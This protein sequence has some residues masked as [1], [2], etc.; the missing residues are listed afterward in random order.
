[1]KKGKNVK[2]IFSHG[3]IMHTSPALNEDGLPLG[4]LD[5]KIF[6]R[7]AYPDDRNNDKLPIEEKESY[8][9]LESLKNYKD[10]LKETKVITICDREAD[11]YELFNLSY[12]INAP[13]LVRAK[14]NRAINKR[15]RYSEEDHLKLWDFMIRQP[16]SGKFDVEVPAKDNHPARIATVELKFGSFTFN[17]PRNIIKYSTGDLPNLKM[18]AIFVCEKNPPS[19]IDPLEWMLLTNLDVN[20]FEEAFEKVRWYCFRW[21]IEMFHKVLKSGFKVED[22]RLGEADR[23]INYLTIMS[24]VAWRIFMVTLIARTN[25]DLPCNLYLNNEEWKV[26]YMK[27]N[28]KKTWPKKIPKIKEVVIWIAKLGGFLGRKGDGDP[29]TITLWRGWKRLADLTEGW[30]LALQC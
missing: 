2:E 25:P 8:R 21:R 1:M 7:E 12:E 20:N 29:G 22:C 6:A 24:I 19:S 28:R 10:L 23:L 11:I 16:V 27:V 30:N 15:S 4:I 18:H 3:L 14:Q 5:Q 17:P 9:W 26:L 13:L